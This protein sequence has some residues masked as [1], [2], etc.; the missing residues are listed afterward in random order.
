M[1]DG[2]RSTKQSV[3]QYYQRKQPQSEAK[4]NNPIQ[5]TGNQKRVAMATLFRI[6]FSYPK[7]TFCA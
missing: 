2:M 1:P 5:P 3:S 7:S 4:Y 6:V